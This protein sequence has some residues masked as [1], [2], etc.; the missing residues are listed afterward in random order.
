[1]SFLKYAQ[2]QNVTRGNG[3]GPLSFHRSHVDGVPF[4]GQPAMLKEEE[5]EEFTEIVNDG[6]VRTFDLSKEEDLA[7]LNEIVDAAGNTWYQIWKMQEYPCPQP[8]GSLKIFV[9]C[10]WTEPFRE[11]AK[12][13]LPSGITSQ[14]Y[15]R[16]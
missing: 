10:V 6:H 2:D 5:Y 1:M 13:R 11:L 7:K 12:H 15:R 16:G 14:S 4:R 8:D 3:R 9:Y